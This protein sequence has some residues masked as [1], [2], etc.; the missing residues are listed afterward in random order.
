MSVWFLSSVRFDYKLVINFIKLIAFLIFM[1]CNMTLQFDLFYLCLE[2]ILSGKYA[3]A[4]VFLI[5]I[6]Q[7][8]NVKYFAVQ[9]F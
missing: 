7:N 8:K 2:M 4:S 3:Q 5:D 9:M 1:D 6:W